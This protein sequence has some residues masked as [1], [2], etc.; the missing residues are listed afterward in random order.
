[1]ASQRKQNLIVQAVKGKAKG[2]EKIA[3][4]GVQ[5][6]VYRI[7]T[8]GG[9]IEAAAKTHPTVKDTVSTLQALQAQATEQGVIVN[10]RAFN[11]NSAGEIKDNVEFTLS[12]LLAGKVSVQFNESRTRDTFAGLFALTE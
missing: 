6:D 3:S 5:R 9:K 8:A 1:M 12:D 10:M 11:Y 7:I 2:P 4:Y